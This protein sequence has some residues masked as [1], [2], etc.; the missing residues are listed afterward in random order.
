MTRAAGTV[1]GRRAA[2]WRPLAL[3]VVAL[4]LCA[5][6]PGEADGTDGDDADSPIPVEVRVATRGDV[7]AVHS[8]TATLE[9]FAE[10]VVVAKVAGE[11]VDI[12]V[13]EGDT[14]VAGQELARLDGARLRLEVE[15]NRANVARL[16][17]EYRR[18]VELHEKGLLSTGAFEGMRHELNALNA[19]LSLARL[20]LAYTRIRAP[21][22]GVVAERMIKKGN[23][24]G[25]NE[26]VF[27]VTTL[28][29]LLA[30]LHV[31]ERDFNKLHAGLPA[32]MRV[33]ALPG[34][35][36][37][38]AIARISPVVDAATG[39]FKV[40]VEVDDPDGALKP[41][42]FG[43]IAIV[44]DT[45]NDAILV[46]RAA[47]VDDQTDPAVFVVDG[48][49]VA[50]KPVMTGYPAGDRIEIRQGLTGTESVVVVGQSGLKDGGK[51]EVVA[52]EQAAP[53][54]AAL[55][56]IDSSRAL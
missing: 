11:V 32:A 34:R 6:K 27:R 48:D 15:R 50:R 52:D 37:A 18:N 39:T 55:A 13:E 14:V 42:M 4:A 35:R 26:S 45:R 21:I 25:V 16:E 17:Q 53:D 28:D 5:C 2:N 33:D 8:G 3:T 56:I 41:G 44:Y 30:Y 51:V 22:D 47:I 7:Q 29:P 49:V 40:T 46:P 31:P 1:P 19:A 36:F 9:A 20:D 24:I 43:R 12:L 23:T 54:D 38:G 10:A